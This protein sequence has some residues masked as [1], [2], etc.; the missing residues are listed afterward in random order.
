MTKQR[1]QQKAFTLVELLVV[2]GIIVV[3]MGILL[4]VAS[5]AQESARRVKCA[6]N[7]RQLGQAILAYSSANDG[8]F[9][10]VYYHHT[11]TA[12]TDDAVPLVLNS[13]G[14]KATN[15]FAN[16][17][18]NGY[19]TA[20]AGTVQQTG[21]DNIP[22]SIFLLLRQSL[23]T[24]EV[25]LCPSAV[26]AN[27]A[28]PDRF[29]DAASAR[30]RSNFSELNYLTGTTNL[31]YSIQVMYPK[32]TATQQGW[33]WDSQ[34]PP[35]GIL[36]ADMNPGIVTGGSTNSTDPVPAD[37]TT[38]ADYTGNRDPNILDKFNSRHHRTLRGVKE[39]QNVLYGDFHVEFQNTPECGEFWQ[40]TT[41]PPGTKFRDNIYTALQVD[42][43]GNPTGPQVM[44]PTATQNMRPGARID[45]VLMPMAQP[46]P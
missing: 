27:I 6:S 19:G 5:R 25:L 24:P 23:I 36:A 3:L 44:D 1:L 28:S 17:A 11:G 14:K 37:M 8:K 29:E 45:T 32:S 43:G 21:W 40:P 15:P 16:N 13:N 22:S 42:T 39:G 38:I 31:S 46:V 41:A 9:P 30:D 33:T 26:S 7:L 20:P 12:A 35:E 34:F 10:R 2:I 18:T 4:P